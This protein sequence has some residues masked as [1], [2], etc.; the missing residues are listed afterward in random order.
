[1]NITILGT[2]AFGLAIGNLLHENT[3]AT[4]TLWT[5]FEEEYLEITST[6]SYDKVLTG[7]NLAKDLNITMDL[8]NALINPDLI[9]LAVPCNHVREV[10]IKIKPY[11]NNNSKIILVS[12][13]LE[14]NTDMLMSEVFSNLKIK[15][16]ISYLAGPSFAKE[17]ILN[18]KIGLTLATNDLKTKE[19]ITKL[20]KGTNI[21]I[22]V[23]DDILGLELYGVIK[24]ILAILMGS[25]D[26][27]YQKDSTKAYYL[28]KVY[29]Y[30]ITL[31]TSLGGKKETALCY[32]A[33]GDIL[34]TCNSRN[35]R[36]YNYGVLLYTNKLEAKTY[37]THFTIEGA[38]AIQSFLNLL[39]RKD[40][41]SL[42]LENL[43][44]YINLKRDLDEVLNLF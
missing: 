42:L 16:K 28:T 15:G 35:S 25:I 40:Q 34:L 11:L 19:L 9:I 26:T 5:N 3:K 21:E 6:N 37:K 7:I 8:E 30:A 27:K 20:F 18:C 13:G 14:E 29:K 1:M 36:N 22:E 33:L 10:L 38:L 43:L 17:I 23:I 44:D 31:V 4:V 41:K 24:N 2:G 32:G 12:K 39:K